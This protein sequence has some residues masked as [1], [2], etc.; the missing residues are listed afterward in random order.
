MSVGTGHGVGAALNV[1]E[2]PHR[3]SPLLDTQGL[4]AGMIV[5]NEPGFY[6]VGGFGIRIEN[7]L[8]VKDKKEFPEFAGKSFLQFERLTHI[9]IQTKMIDKTLLTKE[10]VTWLND[11]HHQVYEKILPLLKTDRARQWLSKATQPI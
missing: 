4:Q 2:G 1:H 7:L 10:E 3:I 8:I 5:S 11:Y 9:P 6:E